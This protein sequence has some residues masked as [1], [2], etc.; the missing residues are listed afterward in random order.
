MIR[1]ERTGQDV[2]KGP[3]AKGYR[4][5]IE[6]ESGREADFPRR[7]R[8][9]NLDLQN[10]KIINLQGFKIF[11]FIFILAALSLR[12]GKQSELPC[13]MWDLSSPSRNQTYVPCIGRR[14]LNHWTTKEVPKFDFFMLLHLW[15]FVREVMAY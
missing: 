7:R 15:L 4:Q 11:Y 10:Y 6:A 13:R 1:E 8:D 3:W 5:L 12:C 9:S 2:R 14:I